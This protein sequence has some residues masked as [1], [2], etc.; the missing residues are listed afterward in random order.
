MYAPALID[1]LKI[2]HELVSH[3]SGSLPSP[4]SVCFKTSRLNTDA[5]TEI[6]RI[7]N[8]KNDSI[9]LITDQGWLRFW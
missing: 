7:I 5:I 8:H 4:G 9:T 6:K 3:R 2:R 1:Q